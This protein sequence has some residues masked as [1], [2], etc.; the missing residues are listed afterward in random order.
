MKFSFYSDKLNYFLWMDFMFTVAV[1][2][3]YLNL[4]CFEVCSNDLAHCNQ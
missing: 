3:W 1:T 4:V 2:P